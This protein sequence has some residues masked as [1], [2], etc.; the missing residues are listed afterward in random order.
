MLE[1]I[2]HWLFISLA[3]FAA[4]AFF[5]AA[6]AGEIRLALANSTCSA[7]EKA[8]DLYRANNPVKFTYICKSSGLLAKGLR[9]GALNADLFVSADHEWMDF[10][11]ANGLVAPDQV[12]SPWGN[13]LVVATPKGSP[14]QRLDWQDLASDKVTA[15]LIGDPSTAPFGHYA[16]ESLEA[17][18]LWDRVKDKIQ[19]RKNIE[20][21]AD[22]LATSSAGTVG[23]LFKTHVT[24][25][26][27]QLHSV[28]KT[29]H[30]PIRYYVAPLKA[31][32]RNADVAG[33]LKFI[34]SKAVKDIF[35]AEGFDVGAL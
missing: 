19:T 26:L 8:G 28:K 34:Q 22:S 21:L 25:Q 4:A 27:R 23:I 30:K 15:I 3:A 10:A 33:F 24:D 17:S 2:R 35:E 16:K 20:L 18:K 29:L 7:M 13:T 5:P 11:V 32:E 1:T 9:G 6:Q 31:T 12:S 14:M